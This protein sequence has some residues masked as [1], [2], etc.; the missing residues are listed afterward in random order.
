MFAFLRKAPLDI[1]QG[2]QEWKKTRNAL[3]LDVRETEEYAAGHIPQAKNQPLSRIEDIEEEITDKQIPIFVYCRSGARS[4]QAE[5][6]MR[7]HG[8]THVKNIGGISTYTG[9]KEYL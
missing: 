6:Y 3:L 1:N 2:I 4:E 7:A 8:Y 9:E 5:K